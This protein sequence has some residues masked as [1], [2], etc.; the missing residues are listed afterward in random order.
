MSLTVAIPRGAL[1]DPVVG[2][3]E[4]AGVAG[5]E[6]FADSRLLL[7]DADDVRLLTV[8]PSDVPTYVE[9]GAA[10]LGITGKDVLVERSD[11]D[12]VEL[13]D[14]GVGRCRMVLAAPRGDAGP[15]EHERRLGLM[16]VATKYPRVARDFFGSKGK[17]VELVEVKGSV[18]LAPLV[19]LADAIVDLVATGETLARNGLEEREQIFSS[20][21][22][23]IANTAS[24]RTAGPGLDRLSSRLVA[25]RV[26]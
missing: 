1:F 12:F 20:T 9:S 14:L 11:L 21:A 18:E 4:R 22:R 8:R 16:K 25:A 17:Q 2:I 13:E 15:A 26:P 6:T 10:D 23:L 7:F 3:L 24:Y 5:P 19:G